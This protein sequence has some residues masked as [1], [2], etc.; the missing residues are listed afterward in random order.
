MLAET[1]IKAFSALG[2]FLEQFEDTDFNRKDLKFNEGFYEDF[3]RIL[4]DAKHYNG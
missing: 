1:K 4:T 2:K 3:S